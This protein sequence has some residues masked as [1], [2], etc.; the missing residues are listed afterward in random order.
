MNLGPETMKEVLEIV[1]GPHALGDE[2]KL[3]SR[4]IHSVRNSIEPAS[5]VGARF[6]NSLPSD[7]K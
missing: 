4:K 1:E 3:K 5:F 6:W 7:L 2:L